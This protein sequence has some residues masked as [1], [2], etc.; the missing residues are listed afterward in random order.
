MQIL[1]GWGW[2]GLSIQRVVGPGETTRGWGAEMQV[3]SWNGVAAWQE[4]TG[5]RASRPEHESRCEKAGSARRGAP[6]PADPQRRLLKPLGFP[7]R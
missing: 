5:T 4:R 1:S 2:G 6:T 7:K 3:G